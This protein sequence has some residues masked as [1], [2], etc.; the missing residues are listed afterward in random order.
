MRE[1]L[2][3]TCEIHVQSCRQG[4][5]SLN[6]ASARKIDPDRNPT[7]C[8]LRWR[9]PTTPSLISRPPRETSR[10]LQ[11]ERSATP[12]LRVVY[13]SAVRAIRISASSSR[14]LQSERSATPRLRSAWERD[15]T[16]IVFGVHLSASMLFKIL[17]FR[18]HACQ[19]PMPKERRKHSAID[20]DQETKKP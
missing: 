19:W 12:R 15:E 7:M 17:I 14:V 2:T 1:R 5:Y 10:V 8:V 18:F 20:D 13:F 9:T 16:W 11:S 3:E 6:V 4:I